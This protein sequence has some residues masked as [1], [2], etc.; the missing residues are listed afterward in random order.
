MV[1]KRDP[2]IFDFRVFRT[3]CNVLIGVCNNVDA[4]V[5]SLDALHGVVSLEKMVEQN[6]SSLNIALISG[7]TIAAANQTRIILDNLSALY[8]VFQYSDKWNYR[9]K[10]Y[11][12]AG[13]QSLWKMWKAQLKS[14]RVHDDISDS[15]LYLLNKLR[16]LFFDNFREEPNSGFPSYI[17][18]FKLSRSGFHSW[19]KGDYILRYP[20]NKDSFFDIRNPNLHYGVSWFMN[21]LG[22]F[23]AYS[24]LYTELSSYVHGASNIDLGSVVKTSNYEFKFCPIWIYYSV[25]LLMLFS[26]FI[27]LSEKVLVCIYN[28]NRCVNRKVI[29]DHLSRSTRCLIY[30]VEQEYNIHDAMR[31]IF[32]YQKC[33]KKRKDKKHNANN[34]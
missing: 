11:Y 32:T 25:W 22:M 20:W 19:Y 29:I 24:H 7:N 17:H 6:V 5:Y 26:I 9:A 18:Y 31:L 14:E 1:C 15:Q 23:G 16:R 21:D 4:D 34:N 10:S 28:D 12:Y 33:I 8:Y 13:C 3:L 27:R 30:E 2:K